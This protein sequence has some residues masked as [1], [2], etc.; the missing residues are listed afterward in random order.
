ME[1]VV[2]AEELGSVGNSIVR[3][4]MAEVRDFIGKV[5]LNSQRPLE[6]QTGVVAVAVAADIRIL[7]MLLALAAPASA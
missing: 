3:A 7:I 5:E 1:F 6:P 4:K 2:G